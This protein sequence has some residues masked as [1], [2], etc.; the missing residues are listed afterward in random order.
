MKP[1]FSLITLIA[2]LTVS[3]ASTNA[4]SANHDPLEIAALL[5]DAKISLL[6]GIDLAE[7]E[8]A[9]RKRAK[10]RGNEWAMGQDQVF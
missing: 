2:S 3:I 4:W 8:D 5:K 9:G 7:M 10:K 6:D 1:F